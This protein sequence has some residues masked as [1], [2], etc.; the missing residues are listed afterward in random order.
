MDD[1]PS[2]QEDLFEAAT[3]LPAAERKAFLERHCRGDQKLLKEIESLLAAHDDAED[4]LDEPV[5]SS[6]AASTHGLIGDDRL[7]GRIGA[8]EIRGL[9]GSGGMGT[10]FLARQ[11]GT[12]R[13]V[14]LKVMRSGYAPTSMRK[15]FEH[16]ARMLAMLHHPG[17]AQIYE[18]GIAETEN[19]P[20]PYFA[21]ELVHGKPLTAYA[22]EAGLT[23]AERLELL[24][25]VADAV[26][27]AHSRG[28]IHRDLKPGNIL[29]DQE[30]RPRV[31]DFGVAKAS[32]QDIA[33]TT[34]HTM[35]G[36][37]VGTLAYMSPEQ[38]AEDPDTLDGRCDVYALGVLLYELLSGRLPH[39][40]AATPLPEMLRKIREVEASPLGTIDGS[41]RG[42]IETI[43]RKAMA[44]LAEHRYAGAA[45]LAEDIRR[46]L[47]HKPI[48]AR[49]PG[50]IEQ[51]RK[52]I[53]RNRVLVAST[54]IVFAS[55]VILVVGVS[56]SLVRARAA[57]QIALTEAAHA[58]TTNRFLQNMLSSVD[59]AFAKGTDTTLLRK[60]LDEASARV[61]ELEDMPEVEA[62]IRATIGG[63]YLFAGLHQEAED[64]LT[65]AY[66][67]QRQVLGEGHARTLETANRLGTL[68]KER[69]QFA[70]AEKIYKHTLDLRRSAL[71]DEH[72]LTLESINNL[73]MLFL[74]TG[75]TAEAEPLCLTAVEGRRRL[76]GDEHPDTLSS[77]ASLG[78]LY[79]AQGRHAEVEP[80]WLQVL[81]G[82]RHLLGDEHPNTLSAMHNVA[83]V[84]GILGRTEEAD[85]TLVE[86]LEARRR[87]LGPEHPD[88]LQTIGNR[89]AG[90]IKA[91]RGEEADELLA[92]LVEVAPRVLGEAHPQTLMMLSSAA[93][94]LMA[95]GRAGEAEALLSRA[96]D[97]T[98][99]GLPPGN[100]RLGLFLVG[101]GN[102]RG[103]LARYEEAERD[104]L[105]AY[106]ILAA[107]PGEGGHDLLRSAVTTL[108]K[109]Y[110]EWERREE[111]AV[112]R[113][114]LVLLLR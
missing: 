98:R 69:G 17:I 28:I 3:M 13:D 21:M 110:E 87:V 89:V 26:D 14:A 75:R 19:G 65:R 37:L 99:A 105:E 57:E 35:P 114:R 24:A 5:L 82:R 48:L 59:P 93:N 18:A 51:A 30:G 33:A 78:M 81:E 23:V 53:R 10:V 101:R 25:A 73:G 56:A 108:I 88:T 44:K 45:D 52:F 66:A 34:L 96:I 83:F 22:N 86:L 85:A 61:H 92:Y 12:S 29:V 50:P 20:Q 102:I 43:V 109:L 38:I 113:E 15:R 71:G 84:H 58:R 68:H 67:L 100:W 62:S 40:H 80:L 11:E 60:I 79:W 27:H 6:S 46:H 16:E 63:T 54:G 91:G 39:D 1:G 76:F 64:H 74:E 104:L 112:W 72:A 36:Q 90:L 103:S 70:D 94:R 7:P 47:Q 77:I 41:L 42:D 32:A 55:L 31:L 111:A 2:S 107:T 97:G 95:A 106:E 4:F 8:Y 49:A 9:L